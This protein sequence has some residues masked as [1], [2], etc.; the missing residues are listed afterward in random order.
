MF[1]FIMAFLICMSD[2]RIAGSL[3]ISLI[4]FVELGARTIHQCPGN[5]QIPF[6]KTGCLYVVLLG[7]NRNLLQC[8]A[9]R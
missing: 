8:R 2:H 6:A 1:R 4:D 5:I 3:Q 7:L 9:K